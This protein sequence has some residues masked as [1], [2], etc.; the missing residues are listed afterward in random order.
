MIIFNIIEIKFDKSLSKFS[1]Q[2]DH[3]AALDRP[4]FCN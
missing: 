3:D 2:L 4:D 1:V